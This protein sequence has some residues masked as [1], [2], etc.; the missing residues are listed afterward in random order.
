MFEF[1]ER[2]E[3]IIM[4]TNNISHLRPKQIEAYTL[5]TQRKNIFL[6]GS[7]G[8]GKSWVIKA[9]VEAY[10]YAKNIA[11]TSTTG[12]SAILIG[13]TTL[14]SYLGIGLG[15]ASVENLVSK[16]FKIPYLR[17]KWTDLQVLI[18][19]EISMLSPD[20]FDKLEQMAR[21]IRKSAK[22]FG[23]IQLILSGDFLQ[24]PCVES[25][26]FCNEAKS[27]SS[28]IGNNVICLS[29]IIRQDNVEFQNC[30]NRV[31][32][33]DI[34]GDVLNLLRTR[35]G[36]S[37]VNDIG[38]KP[39]RIFSHNYSVDLINEGELDKLSSEETE[40]FEYEMEVQVMKT[41]S[42]KTRTEMETRFKK[43][44]SAPVSLQLCVGAQVMLI[45]NLD[46]DNKLVNGSRGVVVNFIENLPVVKFLDGQEKLIDYNIWNIEEGDKVVMRAIQIPLK[47]AY[48]IT[49]H[50]AQ[51]CSLDYAEVDL[52]NCFEYGQAYVALSRVRN[53]EGLSIISLDEDKIV[54]HPKALEFYRNLEN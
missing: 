46:L 43:V 7:A 30:L 17:K 11:I 6:T 9:Y 15:T 24:L 10:K 42:D 37:L 4:Q 14:H 23:G 18:I 27:W 8:T 20:L 32:V 53:I 25:D 31:R 39:T 3:K 19:D 29:E 54:A 44:C 36:V 35:I 13:G 16:I 38:I 47:I 26:N 12:I 21:I 51:G 45:Y 33:G 2:L 34:S 52:G 22:P 48:A 50:R 40:F 41:V 1:E 49:I 5:M 28:C